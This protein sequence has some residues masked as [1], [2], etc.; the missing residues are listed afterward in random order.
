VTRWRSP[1][2]AST[3]PRPRVRSSRSSEI[4]AQFVLRGIASGWGRVPGAG[5]P[6]SCSGAARPD[7]RSAR[8][9][10]RRLDSSRSTN[11]A[12]RSEKPRAAKVSGR[13]A[14]VSG[15][16]AK[17]S[18]RALVPM[19]VL[20]RWSA[21]PAVVET[22]NPPEAHPRRRRADSG[23]A[24]ACPRRGRLSRDSGN[25]PSGDVKGHSARYASPASSAAKR[26]RRGEALLQLARRSREARARRRPA[27]H[28]A[29]AGDN[30]MGTPRDIRPGTLVEVRPAVAC[31][32]VGP[33]K[34]VRGAAVAAH[35]RAMSGERRAIRH[36]QWHARGRPET[37]GLPPGWAAGRHP[38]G[39]RSSLPAHGCRRD[40][41]TRC[42]R[43]GL[44]GAADRCPATESKRKRASE[45]TDRRARTR[46]RS[47][48]RDA[49]PRG[50]PAGLAAVP[51]A[52]AQLRTNR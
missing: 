46:V 25:R 1:A 40:F 29:L 44:R 18:G 28:P 16:A 26:C 21:V 33:R 24:L 34:F 47:A 12:R 37:S 14:T 35:A 2:P 45:G 32:S 17:L 38:R 42:G 15:L 31:A 5:L 41:L 8:E 39:T 22:W 11:P 52:T 6:A 48:S 13:V 4:R 27:P 20:V 23:Q 30:R 7:P 10:S 9:R 49:V 43:L 36:C 3:S 50:R 19:T 51:R